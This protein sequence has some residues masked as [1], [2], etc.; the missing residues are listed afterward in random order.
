VR[1]T[2]KDKSHLFKRLKATDNIIEI[3]PFGL[4]QRVILKIILIVEA[5]ELNSSAKLNGTLK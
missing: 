2:F 5:E 1:E 4:A 3:S